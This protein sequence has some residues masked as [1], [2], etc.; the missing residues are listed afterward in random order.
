MLKL[1]MAM[2][3]SIIFYK[4]IIIDLTLKISWYGKEM[5]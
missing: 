3:I 4:N 2:V 1:I 5:L